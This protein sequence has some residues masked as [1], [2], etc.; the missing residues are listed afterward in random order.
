MSMFYSMSSVFRKGY[1]KGIL[2]EE[3]A[4][5]MFLD[6]IGALEWDIEDYMKEVPID[7]EAY[8][9]EE[10]RIAKEIIGE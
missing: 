9:E 1:Q 6:V 3:E 10:L 2:S 4:A 7:Y 8:R 5:E